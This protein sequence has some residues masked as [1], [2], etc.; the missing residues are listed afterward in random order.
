MEMEE[1]M[2]KDEG[3]DEEVKDEDATMAFLA[4]SNFGMRNLTVTGVSWAIVNDVLGKGKVENDIHEIV[5]TFTNGKGKEV[6]Y[7]HARTVGRHVRKPGLHTK[8]DAKE[9]GDVIEEHLAVKFNW[10]RMSHTVIKAVDA[11][12][13]LPHKI[14]ERHEA[15]LRAAGFNPM[16]GYSEAPGDDDVVEE[17][18]KENDPK[19]E[20]EITKSPEQATCG[21]QDGAGHE[22]HHGNEG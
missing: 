5:G 10:P 3:D 2:K 9:Y 13:R 20:G 21:D 6:K 7:T 18:K 1:A 11:V 16:L 15:S 19:G 14:R 22:D 8:A 4:V 17:W 12:R